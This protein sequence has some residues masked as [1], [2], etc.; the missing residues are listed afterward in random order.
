MNALNNY[1]KVLQVLYNTDEIEYLQTHYN[2]HI[3][4]VGKDVVI[5]TEAADSSWTLKTII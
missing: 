4:T 1:I 3:F 5:I 2:K